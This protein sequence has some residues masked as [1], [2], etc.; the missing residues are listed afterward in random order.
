MNTEFCEIWNN[1]KTTTKNYGLSKLI[2]SVK[3]D[4][5][6]YTTNSFFLS[7]YEQFLNKLSFYYKELA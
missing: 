2:I 4:S 6:Q 5:M 1:I 3:I 7:V